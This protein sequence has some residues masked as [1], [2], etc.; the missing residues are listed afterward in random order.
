MIYMLNLVF[1]ND[2]TNTQ[3]GRFQEDNGATV[4]TQRSKVWLTPKV[5]TN[6]S[7]NPDVAGD[8]VL[9]QVD[10]GAAL[11]LVFSP[12]PDQV[13]VRVL[14]PNGPNNG[15]LVTTS[16]SRDAKRASQNGAKPYQTRGSPFPGNLDQ[17][18]Q[19]S[20]VVLQGMQLAEG[21][22]TYQP[23]P[24]SAA[25]SWV[26]RL[27][28]VTFTT[29]PPASKPQNFHDSYKVIVAITYGTLIAQDLVTVKTYSHDPDMD[30]NI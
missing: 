20:C 22:W 3:N 7:P 14:G 9:K 23:Q 27:G 1:D 16:I 30:V 17:E 6:T 4:V 18:T 2:P 10:T 12:N 13:W 19:Q 15:G 11:Q 28:F 21:G 24:P 5:P 8:W 29:P 26:Q 25:G